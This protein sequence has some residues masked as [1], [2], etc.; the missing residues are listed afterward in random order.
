MANHR[1]DGHRLRQRCRDPV[2]TFVLD[3]FLAQEAAP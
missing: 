1:S 3:G 2:K